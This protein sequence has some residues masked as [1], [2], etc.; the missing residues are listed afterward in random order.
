[1]EDISKHFPALPGQHVRDMDKVDR[2]N[3]RIFVGDG[4]M[5]LRVPGYVD[6]SLK[7]VSFGSKETEIPQFVVEKVPTDATH[8]NFVNQQIPLLLV[9]K[10]EDGTPILRRGIKSND[11]IWQAGAKIYVTAAWKDA[12]GEGK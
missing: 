11:G 9:V 3:T 6:G 4:T 8:T 7:T 10:D 12:E 2:S 5:I 1:M